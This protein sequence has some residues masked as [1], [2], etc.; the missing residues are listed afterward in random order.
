MRNSIVA[1][2]LI[3]MSVLLFGCNRPTNATSEKGPGGFPKQSFDSSQNV[4]PWEVPE[5]IK[6]PNWTQ[7]YPDNNRIYTVP[8]TVEVVAK[9]YM[10][11]L[12]GAVQEDK[13]AK[14]HIIVRNKDYEIDIESG[15]DKTK[16]AITPLAIQLKKG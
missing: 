8:D 6:Y 15:G 12:P 1:G 3:L 2:S 4:I 16:I 7:F 9:W 10:E 11:K 5:E 14:R 13:N